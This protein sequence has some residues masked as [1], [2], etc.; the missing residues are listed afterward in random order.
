MSGAMS[1]TARV[2]VLAAVTA[3]ALTL[4]DMPGQ[5][6][7]TFTART[8]HPASS[9]RAAADW[10]PPTVSV[11]DPGTVISGTTTITADATDAETGVNTVTLHYVAVGGNNWTTLCTDTSAPYSCAWNTTTMV[12]GDYN[13]RAV[14]VDNAGY[15]TTSDAVTTTISQGTTVVLTNPGDVVRGSVTLNATVFNPG[16]LPVTVTIQYAPA[17]STNWT[18]L[19]TDSTAPY[20]CAWNTTTVTGGFYDLRAYAVTGLNTYNSTTVADVQVD[21]GAPSVAMTDPGSPLAGTVT[22]AATASDALSGVSG[23]ALQYAPAGSSS[24]TTMCTVSSPPYS[25]RIDSKSFGGDALYD[26][27]A[28]ATDLAGNTTTS[29]V[30]RNRQV[31]NS[32]SSV[33]ME[34]PGAY[35][36]GTVTLTANANSTAGVTSVRIQRAPGGTSTW[37]DVCTDTTAP[38]TCGWNTTTVAD[39]NYDFRAVLLDGAGKTTTSTVV[40]SRTVDNAPLRGLDVQSANAGATSGRPDTGDTLTYT[41]STQLNLS[42]LLTGWTGSSQTVYV[43]LR[44]GAVL[45]LGT[46]DDTL[47]VFADTQATTPVNLG[48]VNLKRNFVKASKTVTFNATVSATTVSGTNRTVVTITLGTLRPGSSSSSLRTAT[49]NGALVWTPSSAAKSTTGGSSS[50]APATE[51]GTTDRD[52]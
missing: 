42:T 8:S 38:Y 45:G 17:G 48:S 40:F 43:R 20:T 36:T 14:G 27:R 32:I 6:G 31:D 19:C 51:S 49:T 1:S 47:D 34:D 9:V 44:D 28:I 2:L 25:C 29:A 10:T 12:N 21:N 35:L 46:S 18:T 4:L 52:F 7:A 16:L 50:A 24:F 37:T 33:S 26:L 11:R 15:S 23:V 41:Y 13:L 39:G 22:F 30:V 3:V 5:S